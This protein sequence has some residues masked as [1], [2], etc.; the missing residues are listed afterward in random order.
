MVNERG[1]HLLELVHKMGI[2]LRCGAVCT[3]IR[4]IRFGHFDLSHC[5][6]RQQWNY[7]NILRNFEQCESAVTVSIGDRMEQL[8]QTEKYESRLIS[9]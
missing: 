1:S 4:R 5:L 3:K 2:D 9:S 8:S 7:S 6:V